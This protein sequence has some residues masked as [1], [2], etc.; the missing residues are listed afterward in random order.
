MGF[1]F[2][3][4]RELSKQY[5]ELR[6]E[7][8]LYFLSEQLRIL[9]ADNVITEFEGY[10][11]LTFQLFDRDHQIELMKMEWYPKRNTCS[12]KHSWYTKLP[13]EFN[14]GIYV[15]ELPRVMDENYSEEMADSEFFTLLEVTG[16]SAKEVL[17]GALNFLTENYGLKLGIYP[18]K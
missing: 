12:R 11:G 13:G 1:E 18:A 17:S 4:E 2:S 6:E 3:A 16:Y 8:G 15:L 10:Q 9:G 7:L 14:V 5:P